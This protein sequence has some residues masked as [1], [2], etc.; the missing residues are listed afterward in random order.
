M[1]GGL[2][3]RPRL[4]LCVTLWPSSFSSG[5]RRARRCCIS[6]SVSTWWRGRWR[7][8]MP[9]YD[10]IVVGAG[11]GEDGGEGWWRAQAMLLPPS[12]PSPARGKGS[13]AQ[14]GEEKIEPYVALVLVGCSTVSLIAREP[15]HFV[16]HFE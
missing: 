4:T 15:T 12:Q 8:W 9:P 6:P 2:C 10:T 14:G 11:E 13:K 5:C 7:P 1:H 16:L 3:S